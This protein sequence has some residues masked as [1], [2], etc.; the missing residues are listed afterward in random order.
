VNHDVK[1]PPAE[2]AEVDAE[3]QTSLLLLNDNFAIGDLLTVREFDLRGYKYTGRVAMRRVTH[4][5]RGEDYMDGAVLSTR[6]VVLS[7]ALAAQPNGEL[8]Q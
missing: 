2:F 8:V 4:V 5:M 7:L 1:I 6:Y 3:R